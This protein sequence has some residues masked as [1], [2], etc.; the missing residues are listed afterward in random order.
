VAVSAWILDDRPF[1]LLAQVA[2]AARV[3]AWAGLRLLIPEATIRQLDN[4]RSGRRRGL[5]GASEEASPFGRVEVRIGDPAAEILYGHLR[6]G[7]KEEA[8]LA[9]HEAVAWALTHAEDSVFVCCDR[10]AVLTALAELGRGRVAHP[11]D[12]WLLLRDLGLV[13]PEEFDALCRSTAAADTGL[14][15]IPW[16]ISHDERAGARG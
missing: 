6:D 11:F 16:R 10:R 12:L 9:E 2:D 1:G 8:S 13:A 3:R 15:G 14:P 4:D 7:F 5:Y